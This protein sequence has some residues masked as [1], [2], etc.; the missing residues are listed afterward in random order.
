MFKTIIEG[1]EEYKKEVEKYAEDCK[2]M[3]KH[4]I[5]DRLTYTIDRLDADEEKK[6]R[7]QAEKKYNQMTEHQRF[8]AS[9]FSRIV[10][11]GE[12]SPKLEN[13]AQALGL[14]PEEEFQIK[15][16]LK[17]KLGYPSSY[18]PFNKTEDDRLIGKGIKK[19]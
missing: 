3:V 16:K 17:I 2:A 12:Q 14:T 13:M 8:G 19:S 11:P 7:N 15:A 1:L 6:R 10:P 5:I 9:T 18:F 4:T